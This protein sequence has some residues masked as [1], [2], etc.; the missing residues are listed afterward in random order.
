MIAHFSAVLG[1]VSIALFASAAHAADIYRWV[2][3]KGQTHVSDTVPPQYK[4]RATKVDTSVSKVSEQQRAEAAA[5]AAKEKAA[6]AGNNQQPDAAKSPATGELAADPKPGASGINDQ[7]ARCVEW[8]RSYEQ[9]QDCFNQYRTVTGA[10]RSEGYQAC[11][12]V[13]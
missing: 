12:E 1:F 9:S 13:R 4:Q 6:V 2:D 5:R 10:I 7:R 11:T 8:R 3:E